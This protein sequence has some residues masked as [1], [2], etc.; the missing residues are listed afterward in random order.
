MPRPV[1]DWWARRQ[2][3]TGRTEPYP[4]GRFRDAWAPYVPLVGQFRPERN[5]ELLLSQ[6]PPA[7][8]VYLVWVCAIGHDFVATPAEQRARP[9][10]RRARGDWCPVCAAPSLAPPAAGRYPRPAGRAPGGE[11]RERASIHVRHDRRPAADPV[12]PRPPGDPTPTRPGT[13]FVSARASAA[14]SAAQE[15]LR[16]L[17]GERLDCELSLTAITIAQPFHGRLEVW[18][19]VVIPELAIAIEYDTVGRAGDEH[20]GRRERSD[21]RKDALLRAVGW[22]VVRLRQKPLRPLGPHDLV[23]ASVSA[24][25]VDALIERLG[26]IRG[27]LFVDAYRRRTESA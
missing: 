26:E 2:W 22:E 11:E 21:R 10:A 24:Q 4:V 19:D 1:H 25:A 20:V 18:P 23:V 7:A 13:A 15:R 5:A 27:A 16:A 9:G 12:R 3:A 6:I 8:D 14:T 17:I